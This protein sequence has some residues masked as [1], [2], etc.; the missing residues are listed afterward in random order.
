MIRKHNVLVVLFALTLFSCK[1]APL[2]STVQTF[3]DNTWLAEDIRK[4]EVE[5]TDTSKTYDIT[6]FLRVDTEYDYNNA[7]IYLHSTLPDSSQHKEAH[8]FYVSNENGE[9][10]GMKSGSKVESIMI[11]PN[12][13][14]A[15]PGKYT[16][17]LEQATTNQQLTHVSDLGLKIS[18]RKN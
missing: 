14:F 1:K 17:A 4:F 2:Y 16:F 12:K 13:K 11:F 18:E 15:I 3:K 5:I 8:Q 7:W 10:L 9:W 6:F